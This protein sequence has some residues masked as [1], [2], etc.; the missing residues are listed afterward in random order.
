MGHNES[1]P[2][3]QYRS[4]AFHSNAIDEALRL[5][6]PHYSFEELK[7]VKSEYFKGPLTWAK[8]AD[9]VGASLG[10]ALAFLDDTDELEIVNKRAARL[11]RRLRERDAAK[12]GR[13]T[14]QTRVVINL[15]YSTA[16]TLMQ[17]RRLADEEG[18]LESLSLDDGGRA[19][20]LP[21]KCAR[22]K[23]QF[24][25]NCAFARRILEK[26]VG[27]VLASD[28][29]GGV[30]SLYFK[31]LERWHAPSTPTDGEKVEW[32]DDF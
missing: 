15:V 8:L 13:V 10:E 1:K 4:S 22:L 23:E 29:H 26:A 5:L 16:S 24:G 11:M 25:G 32:D 2:D 31:A 21:Q 20:A 17:L 18:P 3:P 7:K 12:A 28:V 6:S 9:G 19:L 30:K 14:K 27:R